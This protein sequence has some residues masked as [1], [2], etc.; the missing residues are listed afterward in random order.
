MK[1]NLKLLTLLQAANGTLTKADCRGA[2][3]CPRNYDPVCGN[4]GETFSNEC[5]MKMMFCRGTTLS[6]TVVGKGNCDQVKDACMRSVGMCT[7]DHRPVCGSDGKTYGNRCSL[8]Y[9]NCE[10]ENFKDP[11]TAVYDGEC[12]ENAEMQNDSPRRTDCNSKCSKKKNKVCGTNGIT[13][14]NSCELKNAACVEEIDIEV[15]HKGKCAEEIEEK[16][17]IESSPMECPQ[18]CN[19]MLDQVCGTD[20]KVYGNECMLNI[21]ACKN[22]L[23]SK[24]NHGTCKCPKKCPE[25]YK[26]VCVN[27]VTYDSP[28]KA[29]R[30]ACTKDFDVEEILIDNWGQ[31][32][33][34][35]ELSLIEGPNVSLKMAGKTDFCDLNKIGPVN[36]MYAPVCGVNGQDF[37]NDD[38]ARRCNVEIAYEGKCGTQRST[39]KNEM[40]DIE[41]RN[42]M[43]NRMWSPVCG[44]N[45]QTFSNQEIAKCCDVE[46]AK[47]CSCEVPSCMMNDFMIENGFSP[48][49]EEE[50]EEVEEEIEE[51]KICNCP[52]NLFWVCGDDGQ[53]YGNECTAAC[54]G[55]EIVK[56][57]R[58]EDECESL[59]EEEDYEYDPELEP[60]TR[61]EPKICPCGRDYRPVC[62]AGGRE[63]SNKCLAE[64]EELEVTHECKCA[65][66]TNG[67]CPSGDE[68]LND[69]GFFGG[70]GGFGNDF[71]EAQEGASCDDPCFNQSYDQKCGLHMGSYKR[72]Q[73][74]CELNNAICRNGGSDMTGVQKCGMKSNGKFK[75]FNDGCDAEDFGAVVVDI[76]LCDEA[77]EVKDFDKKKDKKN[78]NK[79]Q[80]DAFGFM[81]WGNRNPR[82]RWLG[83]R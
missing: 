2:G 16:E 33:S 3:M 6:D 30:A 21:E 7:R 19:R 38:I 24:L 59:V 9:A 14:F 71:E 69:F 70:F 47:Y 8:Q 42:C 82:F 44:V 62:T 17:E 80:N 52:R 31:C 54:Q 76:S 41:S 45:G 57:C 35:I 51:P 75:L 28:C 10:F 83:G 60:I 4:T 29:M 65:S 23:V 20:Y 73:H 25:E 18:Y 55:A 11:V 58:C 78:K 64:C 1:V 66:I 43:A 27:G 53:T 34:D 74:S 26:P 56:N 72:F 79:M 40:C 12:T 63:F 81:P 46:I 22:T 13:Y 49:E 15:A 77:K 36:R 32:E 48:P 50:E 68:L 39:R 67:E 5:M 61:N 37:D